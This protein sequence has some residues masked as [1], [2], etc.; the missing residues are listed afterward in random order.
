MPAGLI[1]DHRRMHIRG[2]FIAELFQKSIHRVGVDLRC[3]QAR[4]LAVCRTNR[5]EDVE[6]IVLVLLNCRRTRAHFCPHAGDRSM[7]TETRFILV[8]AQDFLVGMFY[9]ELSQTLW[10]DFFLNA[11]IA[12]GEVSGW[13]VRGIR[14]L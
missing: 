6:I 8:V 11:S 13:V 12:S 2:Q 9:L 7:L 5:A 4:G 1:E 14:S 10:K 3:D